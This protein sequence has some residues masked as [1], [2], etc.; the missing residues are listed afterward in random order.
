M[1][2]V[3]RKDNGTFLARVRKAGFKPVSQSFI[4][5][6][7]ALAWGRRIEADMQAGRHKELLLRPAVISCDQFTLFEGERSAVSHSRMG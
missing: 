4:R 5:K 2:T 3:A 1:T 7:D 6:T